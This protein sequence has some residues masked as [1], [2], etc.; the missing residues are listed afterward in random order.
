MKAWSRALIVSGVTLGLLGGAGLT[1]SQMKDEHA[2]HDHSAH[3]KDP[4]AGHDHSDPHHVAHEN[5]WAK[6]TDAIAVVHPTQG[7]KASG[8]VRFMQ[9]GDSVHVIAEISGLS[10][11]GTHGFHIHE[12][13]DCSAPDATS[14]GSH[15]NP[16]NH[17]HAG[18]NDD[19]RHAG[20]LG[21]LRADGEGKAK[22]ELTLDNVSVA[23]IKN[24]VIG[25]AVVVHT[26]ADDLKSQPTGDAGGRIGC[27]V[28]GVAKAAASEGASK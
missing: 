27:G 23:G 1:Y 5:L 13:G 4:H 26:K 2:G 22:L 9:H 6:V 17:P 21:N 3:E 8:T 12:F 20:D 15:Y 14:A 19:K 28:I 16:D 11:N 7:N 10:P 24:P 25:R 18:P